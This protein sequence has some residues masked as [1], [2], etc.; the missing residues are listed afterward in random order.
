MNQDMGTS[1][2]SSEEESMKNNYGELQS[3]SNLE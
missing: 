2:E 3:I 1:S